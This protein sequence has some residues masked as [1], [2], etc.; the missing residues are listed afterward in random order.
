MNDSRFLLSRS[1]CRL[2]VS[3]V[4][5]AVAGAG[6]CGDGEAGR[7]QA[8]VVGAGGESSCTGAA[9][10]GSEPG[11]GGGYGGV[12]FEVAGAAGA[13]G[14]IPDEPAVCEGAVL[15]VTFRGLSL[16]DVGAGT[17]FEFLPA[18]SAEPRLLLTSSDGRVHLVEVVGDAASVV[19]SY[20]LPDPVHDTAACGLTNLRLDPEFEQNHYLYVSY[21]VDDEVTRLMRYTW[22]EEEGIRDGA[23]IVETVVEKKEQWHRFGSMGFEADGTMWVLVGDHFHKAFG[24]TTTDKMGA[25]LRIVPNRDPNG[26]GFIPA[27]GNLAATFA[28]GTGGDGGEG[29]IGGGGGSGEEEPDPA[30]FAYGFR[31]PWRGTRDS[32]GRVWVGDVGLEKYE[33]VN[34]VTTVGQNFGWA[35]HEGPCDADCDGF[36]DPIAHYGRSGEEPYAADDPDTV[37]ATK[38][39]I[40]LSEIYESPSRDRYCGLMDDV[41]VFGDLFTGWVRA[42]R[43]DQSGEVT[44]N[45]SIG[46]LTDVT[47]WRTGSD[48]FAYVLTLD[49]ELHRVELA[50]SE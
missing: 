35:A 6:A 10:C 11:G 25:L 4:A 41:V 39:A 42:L 13:G 32:L 27:Q 15:A 49:G 40:W 8:E 50:P 22:S 2:G 26:E 48:G 21:C 46:H 34:L 14:S 44:L 37:P 43:A 33:E 3:V 17:D 30:V 1:F 28:E 36:T 16:G 45:Q 38:R 12:P 19:E 20:E 23:V 5:L 24:Q 29:G 7:P 18:A 31:S 47:A 9:G